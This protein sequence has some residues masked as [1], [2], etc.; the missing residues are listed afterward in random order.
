MHQTLIDGDTVTV[1]GADNGR[2][3]ADGGMKQSE[4]VPT[5]R[6]GLKSG[7]NSSWYSAGVHNGLL[8]SRNRFI[9]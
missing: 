4:S 1:N 5:T 6:L 7:L 8:F 3:R 2:I 9:N